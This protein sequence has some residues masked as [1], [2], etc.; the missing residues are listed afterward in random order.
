MAYHSFNLQNI[1]ISFDYDDIIAKI[2]QVLKTQIET[3]QPKGHKQT[4]ISPLTQGLTYNWNNGK[5]YNSTK[6]GG[7]V[8]NTLKNL[9]YIFKN[10][11]VFR[12]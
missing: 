11:Q 10:K 5:I 12:H 1:K 8:A 4:L 2:A 6:K 9:F 7:L 3:Q